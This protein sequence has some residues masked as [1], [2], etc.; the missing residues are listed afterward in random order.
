[1]AIPSAV[2]TVR[3]PRSPERSPGSERVISSPYRLPG[4]AAQGFAQQWLDGWLDSEALNLRNCRRGFALAEPHAAQRK[5]HFRDRRPLL[6]GSL[7][8]ALATLAAL[9]AGALRAFVRRL[10]AALA[11]RFHLAAIRSSPK[12]CLAVWPLWAA[13]SKQRLSTVAGPPSACGWRC[14]TVRKR[15]SLQRRPWS[16]T[17]VH[18]QS[19]R[20]QIWRATPR[21]M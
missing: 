1:M 6:V 11:W 5:V 15:R 7:L 21:G 9:L 16:S 3:K 12:T 14:S 13:Q 10:A 20:C 4:Q 18:C 17:K 2:A 19:S 8:L